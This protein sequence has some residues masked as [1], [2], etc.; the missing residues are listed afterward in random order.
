ML[1]SLVQWLWATAA[2]GLA[3]PARAADTEAWK[4]R[5]IYQTMTDR[6]ARTDGSTTHACNT[7]AGLYCGGTWQGMID[8]LDYIQDMGFDAVMISPIVKNVDGR[9]SYGEAYHGYWVQDLYAL[10]PHFGS[11]E[12]LL[13]L[14]KAVHDRGMYLMMDTVINNMAYIGHGEHPARNINYSSLKPF[15][16]SKYYHPYCEITDYSDYPMAQECWTGDEIVL[17]PD[18]KTEDTE[19]QHMLEKWINHTMSTYSIDGLR[20]DAAK[21]VTPSFLHL[22][23]K[24]TGNAFV[25]GEVFEKS[26]DKICSYQDELTSFPNYPIYYSMLDAFT[27]GD[28]D[29]LPDQVQKMK[30]ACQDVTTLVSFSE[31]HDLSRYAGFKK[32]MNL[33]KNVLTFTLLFDGIPMIYQ[34]QEQH[35]SGKHDPDNREAI[36][37]SGYDTDAPLYKLTTTLNTLRKHAAQVDPEYLNTETYPVYKGPSEMAFRKGREGRQVIMVLS[38]QGSRS[39]PYTIRM[40]NAYQPSMEVMDILACNTY[41]TNDMGQLIVPMDKGEP[42][43]LFPKELMRGSGLCGHKR[44]NVSWT[45]FKKQ[46]SSEDSKTSGVEP[47][48][49]A[50][51]FRLVSVGLAC[52][53]ALMI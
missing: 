51:R 20:L 34:G 23:Q 10:N 37:L 47:L 24:A 4:S 16:D 14:S 46:P 29:S 15:D 7:T 42:R 21:H 8:R 53:V 40:T 39:G 27:L 3:L 52:L 35:S 6:F 33:A 11:H 2:F 19:V 50:G 22:F 9:V 36:W 5:T 28:T 13:N 25:T 48:R 38:T 31:N 1:S 49:D 44:A 43:V 17:L 26:V 30:K 32:D 41:K 18:L 45:D 12:D